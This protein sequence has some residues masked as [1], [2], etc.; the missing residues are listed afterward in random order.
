MMEMARE[1]KRLIGDRLRSD[2]VERYREDNA[3]TGTER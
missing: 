3:C 1:K 2:E